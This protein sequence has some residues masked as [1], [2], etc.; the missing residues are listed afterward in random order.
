MLGRDGEECVESVF[1]RSE[2]AAGSTRV[3]WPLSRPFPF[4][5]RDDRAVPL[6]SG[7][8]RPVV[9]P[10]DLITLEDP[11]LSRGDDRSSGCGR[12][13]EVTRSLNPLSRG[14]DRSSGCGRSS[15]VT[16]SPGATTGR[17]SPERSGTALSSRAVK[18][19]GRDRGQR[20]RVDP[21]AASPSETHAQGRC[22]PEERSPDQNLYDRPTSAPYPE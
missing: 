5:A 16:R 15:E 1:H 8:R 9:A 12:S 14:D 21:A 20:T 2:A 17:L 22:R 18:G 19:K 3:R 10:G 6:R 13:S 7:E 11:P 4:T